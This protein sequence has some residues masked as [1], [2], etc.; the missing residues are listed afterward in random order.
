MDVITKS[1]KSMMY[2]GHAPEE[3]WPHAINHALFLHDKIT[4]AITGLSPN[5][6]WDG[7]ESKD[8]VKDLLDM[9]TC[10]F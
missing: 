5:Y 3:D 1:A 2:R 10:N 4:D 9:D 8:P 7:I 6:N